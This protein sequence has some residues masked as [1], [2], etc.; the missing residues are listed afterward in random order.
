MRLAH[1][2]CVT[3]YHRTNRFAAGKILE[4]NFRCSLRG[5]NGSGVYFALQPKVS[6]SVLKG[7]A[8]VG[9]QPKGNA[10]DSSAAMLGG[11][12]AVTLKAAV[13]LGHVL[14]DGHA[15]GRNSN[16]KL[17]QSDFQKRYLSICKVGEPC[18]W[19]HFAEKNCAA[20]DRGGVDFVLSTTWTVDECVV[21]NIDHITVSYQAILTIFGN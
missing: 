16:N 9:E 20:W 2:P 15:P 13:L 6:D 19:Q 1:G 11:K 12:G 5:S 17:S 10:A 4:D 7:R 14:I 21:F 18:T 3:L 8:L